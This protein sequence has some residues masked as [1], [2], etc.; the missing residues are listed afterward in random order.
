MY[1]EALQKQ[2][3]NIFKFALFVSF[4]PQLMQGPISRWK[5]LKETLFEEHSFSWERFESGIQRIIW[6]YFKKMVI[7]DRAAIVLRQLQVIFQN[8]QEHMHF[9]EC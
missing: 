3:T 2:K 1:T 8:I 9:L 6:G 5:D 7:A 4:F